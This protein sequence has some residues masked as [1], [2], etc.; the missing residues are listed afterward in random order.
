[1]FSSNSPSESSLKFQY[2]SRKETCIKS[3]LFI[4]ILLTPL[5]LFQLVIL[6]S[7]KQARR[8]DDEVTVASL[9]D[10]NLNFSRPETLTN[11]DVAALLNKDAKQTAS[12]FLVENNSI[13]IERVKP[14]VLAGEEIFDSSNNS[15]LF[16]HRDKRS[17]DT[18]HHLEEKPPDRNVISVVRKANETES[19]ATALE[20]AGSMLP[21]EQTSESVDDKTIVMVSSKSGNFRR[22]LPLNELIISPA[23]NSDQADAIVENDLKNHNGDMANYRMDYVDPIVPV[24]HLDAQRDDKLKALE[25]SEASSE[26]VQSL[27]RDHQDMSPEDLATLQNYHQ[28]LQQ[29]GSQLSEQQGNDKEPEEPQSLDQTP[30][31][32]EGIMGLDQS[33]KITDED[34]DNDLAENPSSSNQIASSNDDDDEGESGGND[35]LEQS[36]M[37]PNQLV[38]TSQANL[39]RQQHLVASTIPSDQITD[40]ARSGT[41]NLLS[42]DQI[43]NSLSDL[44]A[45][46]GHHY[47]KKKKK[48][49]K[50]IIK[51]KKK[52]KYKKKVKVI[53]IKKKKKVVKK[54]K[55]KKHHHYK[56][57]KKKHHDHGHYYMY[58]KVPKKKSW[59]F[60]FKKGNK[61]HWSK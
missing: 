50:I 59:E 43:R 38:Q 41:N 54:K 57:K 2:Q 53:K 3:I 21:G 9:S 25:N 55:K 28:R 49:K 27:I 4:S 23:S 39:L 44:N 26:D 36:Q 34:S 46:A 5:V 37:E 29:I 17:P 58:A 13:E 48:V 31:S 47:K 40:I 56:E 33:S 11:D 42:N 12:S 14:L 22:L 32:F 35:E 16:S 52:K 30:D 1:M 10:K 45:A 61:K 51:K 18:A 7:S 60:G 19:N 6:N 24:N 8:I 20:S 15:D